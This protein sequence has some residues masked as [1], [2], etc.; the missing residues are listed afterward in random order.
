LIWSE[1]EKIWEQFVIQLH[2][3]ESRSTDTKQVGQQLKEKCL[4]IV[5]MLA[6]PS[7]LPP[8]IDTCSPIS[9]PFHIYLEKA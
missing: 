7:T 3:G 9:Y 2:I 8:L 1:E 6:Q 4:E 5:E